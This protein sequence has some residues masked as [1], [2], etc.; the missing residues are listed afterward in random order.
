MFVLT[1]QDKKIRISRALYYFKEKRGIIMKYRLSL[2]VGVSSIGSAV[3]SLN[4]K[5]ESMEIIDCGCCIFPVSEGAKKRRTKRGQRKNIARR[6]LRIKLLTEALREAGLWP[7]EDSSI[8]K[9]LQLNPYAIR[10]QAVHGKLNGIE[11]L[12]RAILH[13]AKHRGAGFVEMQKIENEKAQEA[14]SE[15]GGRRK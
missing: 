1:C 3:V 11:E 6:K 15:Q 9:L 14:E 2:D 4:D 10:A 12:G 7:N 5:N 13:L 8:G